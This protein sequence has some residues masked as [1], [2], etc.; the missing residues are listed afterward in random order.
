MLP[1]SSAGGTLNTI[2]NQDI[3]IDANGSG[4]FVINRDVDLNGDLD[5]SG[6]LN[7]ANLDISGNLNVDGNSSFGSSGSSNS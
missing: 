4:E 7:L 1:L 5:V 6:T 2:G 3:V